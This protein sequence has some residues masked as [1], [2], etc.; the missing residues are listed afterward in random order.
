MTKRQELPLLLFELNTPALVP[1]F[2]LPPR[3]NHGLLELTNL[4]LSPLQNRHAEM[5][6]SCQQ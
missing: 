1:L 3:L 6:N 4:E 5:D 2:Q